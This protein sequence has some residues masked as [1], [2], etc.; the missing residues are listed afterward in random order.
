MI[1]RLGWRG[2]LW[3]AAGR[4]RALS[5][6]LENSSSLSALARQPGA[7]SRASRKRRIS[8]AVAFHW[9]GLGFPLARPYWR[10]IACCKA[11]TLSAKRRRRHFSRTALN[12]RSTALS[13]DPL[14]GVGWSGVD[15]ESRVLG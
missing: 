5:Y 10:P 4:G 7:A 12:P 14:V 1:K 13:Q 11:S 15:V 9:N 3:A 8:T 2:P 6:G